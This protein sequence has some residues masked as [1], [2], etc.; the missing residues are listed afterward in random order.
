[1]RKSV[2]TRLFH[3]DAKV[4]DVLG[5]FPLTFGDTE[6]MLSESLLNVRQQG[7]IFQIM[8]GGHPRC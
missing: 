7:T 6:M 2:S 1:M 4:E 8:P 5:Y 3:C